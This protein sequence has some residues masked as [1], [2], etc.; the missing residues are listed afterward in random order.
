MTQS[1][2]QTFTAPW[3]AKGSKLPAGYHLSCPVGC[4]LGAL[5]SLSGL[6]DR[7]QVQGTLGLL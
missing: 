3:Y 5:Y 1:T 6:R 2:F 4:C 7:H